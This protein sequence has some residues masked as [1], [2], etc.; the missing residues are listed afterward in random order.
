M[1][2]TFRTGLGAWGIVRSETTLTTVFC[3][4]DGF[5]TYEMWYNTLSEEKYSVISSVTGPF[6]FSCH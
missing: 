4:S 5:K 6:T 1:T 2:G 3:D